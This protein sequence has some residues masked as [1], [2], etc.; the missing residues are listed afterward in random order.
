MINI[1]KSIIKVIVK[2]NSS[3]NKIICFDNNKQ[4]Y[5][6]GIKAEAKKNKANKELIKFL[7]KTLNKKVKIK[8][9]LKSR[10]KIIKI[11]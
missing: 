4:A 3:K 7:S 5:K 10:K 11:G 2:P 6:I 1:D 8:S 9:G